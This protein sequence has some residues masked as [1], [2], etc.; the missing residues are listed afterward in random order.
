M[1]SVNP[2]HKKHSQTYQNIMEILVRD[3]VEKQLKKQ[4][5]NLASYIDPIEVETF[6]LNRL[7][8]MYASSLKGKRQQ[9]IKAK[10][11]YRHDIETAVRQGI[12]AVVRDPLRTADPLPLPVNS[13][14]QDAYD[15]LSELEQ[16]LSQKDLL[17]YQHLSWTNL[18]DS[19]Q[20]V[21]DQLSQTKITPE[22]KQ[23]AIERFKAWQR[24]QRESKISNAGEWADPRYHL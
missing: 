22:Q 14:N 21:V 13:S 8:P 2:M 6:A 17:L 23:E 24:R 10:Q 5:P 3:E 20:Y 18:V 11:K 9:E 4:P 12:A 19:I 7:P 15:A 16:F 1:V